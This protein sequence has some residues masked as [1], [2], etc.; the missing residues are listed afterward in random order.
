MSFPTTSAWDSNHPAQLRKRVE[1]KDLNDP[2]PSKPNNEFISIDYATLERWYGI[3]D[4]LR[5][6]S[7]FRTAAVLEELIDLRDEIYD[8]RDEIY[9]YLR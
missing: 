4:E 2:A 3:L 1:E 6:H 8:L 5:S 9:S 7:Y